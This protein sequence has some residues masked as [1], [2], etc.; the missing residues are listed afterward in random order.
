MNLRFK[1]IVPVLVLW[2]LLGGYLFMVWT[3]QALLTSERHQIKLTEHHLD[4]VAE[5]LIPLLLGKNL[6]TIHENLGALL[7]KNAEWKQLVL[8]DEQGRQ[9]YPIGPVNT[10][11]LSGLPERKL[12]IRPIVFQTTPLGELQASVDLSHTLDVDRDNHRAMLQLILVILGSITL[13]II[14]IL[15]FTVILPARK[16]SQAT[17]QL[18]KGNFQTALPTAHDD[19]I[20]HLVDSFQQM[21]LELK[22]RHDALQEE[23]RMRSEAQEALHQHGL[24]LEQAVLERTLEL[25]Q[26]RD[27]AIAANS[28]KSTFLANMSHELRTPMNAII[29]MTHLALKTELTPR[30]RNYLQKVHGA[31]QHLLG[32]INDILD[33]SKIEADKIVLEQCEFDLEQL[34][35]EIA[36]QLGEKASGKELELVFD[37][38]PDTPRQLLGDTLRLSQILLNLG[39]NAV[40]FT[41]QGEVNI[42]VRAE[43][44]K[45]NQVLLVFSVRDTGIGISPEQMQRL[46]CSF[47]QADSSTTRRYGGTGLGLAISKRLVE[48]MGGDIEVCSEVGIGSTFTF[49]LRL[50]LGLGKIPARIPAPD[51]RGRRVLIV[52]DNHSAREVIGHLLQSMTFRTEAVRSGLEALEAISRADAANTPFDAVLIDWQMPEMDGVT[53]A[54]RISTLDIKTRPVMIMV[55]AYGRDDLVEISQKAGIRDIITKPVTA[56]TLFDC[57]MAQLSSADR[58]TVGTSPP[59]WRKTEVRLFPDARV[60]LVEDNLLNMEVALELLNEHRIK[61]DTAAN[62]KIALDKLA[63][64][65][66]DLI[67]MDMQMPVMDGITATLEIRKQA[68]FASLPILAMT[69]NALPADRTRCLEAGMNDHIAKPIDPDILAASL[70]HWLKPKLLSGQPSGL[71]QQAL[72]VATEA[73]QQSIEALRGINGLDVDI[74]LRFSRGRIK[75]YLTL[76]RKFLENNREFLADLDAAL[77]ASDWETAVR[78]AHTLKGT[79]GQIGAQT[80]RAMAELVEFALRRHESPE[81]LESIK[82]Q[83]AEL[84]LPLLEN[85]HA[86]LPFFAAKAESNSFNRAELEEVFI[87]LDELLSVSDFSSGHLLENFEAPLRAALGEYF[88]RISQA[89]S[90][91][92]FEEART[93]LKEA[94]AKTSK[95]RATRYAAAYAP[96]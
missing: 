62:G 47:E 50:P 38:S 33:Y 16:L 8:L 91:F 68:Q 15:E 17:A 42:S 61:V 3:P 88:E 56:S 78:L 93:T 30:Q 92:E 35:D 87:R 75:L 10:E 4:S 55:T 19:E 74:G 63:Q 58:Q 82:K 81:V 5:S 60:L 83:I 65:P 37:A 80:I 12:L 11:T 40:K 18:A 36:S 24:Q 26:A 84:L 39:T 7:E 86:A 85:I 69:A 64:H 59:A 94:Q 9:L 77:S 70:Q 76:L 46:F 71:S 72:P 67:L 31:G 45:D 2:T 22:A 49:R 23:I 51:L 53:T 20:G 1:L 54:W 52:D 43:D 66:Y 14:G 89:V 95:F 34:L 57:L 21:Q 79:S 32:L 27:T 96:K 90:N 6:A 25:E 73:E 44:V 13:L 48:L 29:G 28:A 41:E